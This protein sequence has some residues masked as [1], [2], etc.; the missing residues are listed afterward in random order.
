MAK[1]ANNLY[2]SSEITK[3]ALIPWPALFSNN[4]EFPSFSHI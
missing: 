4:A 3:T 2:T 1:N